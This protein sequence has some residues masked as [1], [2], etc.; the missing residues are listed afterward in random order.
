MH[1]YQVTVKN[2]SVTSDTLISD[3]I[4]I[5]KF[6]WNTYPSTENRLK[7]LSIGLT[8]A[9]TKPW[10]AILD[11][12]F[13]IQNDQDYITLGVQEF[14]ISKTFTVISAACKE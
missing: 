6:V 9:D 2:T 5:M 12:S 1:D 13:Y 7:Y 4:N 10:F 3:A 11:E 8:N 14:I